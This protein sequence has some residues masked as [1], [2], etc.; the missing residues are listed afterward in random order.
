MLHFYFDRLSGVKVS[1]PIDITL[2][3]KSLLD[4]A[5]NTLAHYL[6][7]REWISGKK[8]ANIV[9]EAID[10]EQVKAVAHNI[11]MIDGLPEHYIFEVA[12]DTADDC[13]AYK[14]EFQ[15]I[16]RLLVERANKLFSIRNQKGYP[17]A[18]MDYKTG[19]NAVGIVFGHTESDAYAQ[20]SQFKGFRKPSI[21]K[22]MPDNRY[23]SSAMDVE[24]ML[25]RLQEGF[26]VLP[27]INH[28]FRQPG[29][30]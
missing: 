15:R 25:L 18:F 30:N 10:N 9:N 27:S 23:I 22:F 26:A 29:E 11:L 7:L 24:Q 14:P 8:F 12:K 16:K 2:E 17:F 1:G 6:P 21:S 19:K 3:Q 4:L 13:L 28:P 5:I 20:V